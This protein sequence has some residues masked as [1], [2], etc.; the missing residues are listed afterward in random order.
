MRDDTAS[1]T[2]PV[3]ATAAS[4][5]DIAGRP[6]PGWLVRNRN[7]LLLWGAYGVA[8]VG[9]HLSEMALLKARGGMARTDA[10]RVQALITFGFF[11]PFVVLGPLAGWWSDR[12]SRKTTMIVADLLR[13]ALVF[14]LAAVV[15]HLERVVE[16]ASAVAI[17][18]SVS[19]TAVGDFAIV[20]PLAIVGALAAFFSPARQSM[21]PTLIRND[22]LV[23][24]NALISALGTIGTI[25][26][27]VVGGYLVNTV[28]PQWNYKINAA[29]FG[30]SALLVGG[31]AMSRTRAADHP[32]MRGIWRPVADG[33]RYVRSHR[34]TLQ[35][36]L[37][38]TVFWAAAGVVISVVPAI[39]QRLFGEN[40]AA[41]GT[42]RGL[43]GVGLA[44]GA[45]VMTILG[46][47]MPIQIA[48][49]GA[50]GGAV[51]WTL[52]L[53]GVYAFGWGVVAT[54][55]CLFGIGGAGAALLVTIMATLQRFVPDS[56]RGRVFGVSDMATM[57]A[58][59]L[60]TGAL[61]LPRIPN[62]DRYI[63]VILLGVAAGFAA[64]T[65][66][67]WCEYR[68]GKPYPAILGV[69]W[70]IA[71]F[72]ARYWF[73]ARRVGPC[74]IP[75]HGPVIVA[76]NHTAGIDPILIYA[77]NPYRVIGFLVEKAYYNIPV[78]HWFQKMVGC[79]PVD[80]NKPGPSVIASM[81]RLLEQ[82]GCLGIFPQG[83]FERP[84]ESLGG[85]SGIGMIALRSGATVIPCH[86]GGT[87]Y[88]DS[89][90]RSFL[91]R[92]RV[93]IRYGP[94]VDLSRFRGRE[95]DRQAQEEA[96][97]LIMETI[98]RLGESG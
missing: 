47:A 72:Y 70:K 87:R 3:P 18:G 35:M 74:T 81:L 91:A 15:F 17:G 97:E 22:Q 32:P 36:I 69:V 64:A 42:F 82:G 71:T 73:D 13:A 55:L 96:A 85:K 40:Y 68:R 61:G 88:Y 26:S 75:R 49:L 25:I 50:L 67:A 24:A 34:R 30:L 31:I 66:F 37:L 41:A 9:D 19:F 1:R 90:L 51:L 60:A 23:R 21:L 5:R 7:F 76:A 39:V 52:L 59:V 89:V 28:G 27:A 98:R 80:R 12:F 57:G 6:L 16:P 86:I 29:T 46:P 54:G 77:T 65:W 84:G 95:R 43:I 79:I 48:V 92:Q 45:T 83:T 38:G 94:P 58:M 44:V 56:R 93:R 62:V 53:A 63:S 2:A 14:N 8:A 4:D 78:A 20:I 11:L 10:T 33:F